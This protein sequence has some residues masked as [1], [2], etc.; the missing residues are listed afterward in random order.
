M[1]RWMIQEFIKRK[2]MF[3]ITDNARLPTGTHLTFQ[4]KAIKIASFL[5]ETSAEAI[6]FAVAGLAAH[7]LASAFAPPLLGIAV[8]LFAS[9]LV[10]KIADS[11]NPCLLIRVSK[12]MC[13]LKK[14]AP[15]LETIL[16]I[17]SLTIGTLAKPV[18]YALGAILGA[19]SA[20]LLDIEN[21][22]LIQQANRRNCEAAHLT[23]IN[24]CPH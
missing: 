13:Y 2:P 19:Y 16:M 1:K 6:A 15:H 23:R 22:K 12:R 14:K 17:F 9:G 18:S 24:V 3:Y 7:V 21:Y 20:I 10:V 5:Y 4:Q 11:Y 8:G